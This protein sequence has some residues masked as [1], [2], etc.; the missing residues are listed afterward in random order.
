MICDANSSSLLINGYLKKANSLSREHC[1]M[2]SLYI[3]TLFLFLNIPFSFAQK[4]STK[5]V[6]LQEV[7]VKSSRI[8]SKSLSIPLTISTRLFK[9]S[10]DNRQQF[11]LKD[12][13]STIP[14]VYATNSNNFSQDLRISIRG[15]GSRSAFGIRGIKI[16]VDGIPETT[17]DG[18]GQIDNLN[19]GIIERIEVIKGPSASLYGNASGGV[20][21]IYTDNSI[22]ND[23]LKLGLTLGSD[24]VRQ[25]QSLLGLKLNKTRLFA[26]GTLTRTDGFR[27]QSSYKNNNLNL[28]INH[29]ISD[30][31][32]IN[33][34]LNYNDSPYAGDPGGL[35]LEEITDNRNQARSRNLEYKTHEKIEQL[36]SGLSMQHQWNDQTLNSYAFY[37]NRAFK[38]LLPFN[39]GGWIELDRNY[40]GLGTNYTLN[41]IRPTTKSSL[42]I[43]IDVANQRD[44][45]ERFKNETGVKGD[46]TL[47][48]IESFQSLGVFALYQISF[49]KFLIRSGIRFD[50]NRLK[51][52]DHF[53]N[54]GNQSDQI[55]LNAFSPSIGLSYEFSP[56]QFFYLN[57]STSF[58]TPVLS[59]LSAN[60][61]Q[62]GGFNKDLNSQKSTNFE[63]GYKFSSPF[64]KG[65]LS[66]FTIANKND[67]VPYELENYPDRDFY[68]NAGESNR[69]GAEANLLIRL[70]PNLLISLGYTYSDFEYVRYSSSTETYDG[71]QLPGIPKHMASLEFQYVSN[72][73]NLRLKNQLFGK[74][75]TN[76]ANTISDEGYFLS[77]LN[78]GYQLN[79]SYLKVTPFLGI[80]NIFDTDYNDNIRINAFGG[81]Y[82][83][84]APGIAF[85]GGIRL[86]RSF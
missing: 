14:G 76:D 31:T 11:S 45:R 57:V 10:Q 73:F 42:Q 63:F 17:P 15:Y 20:L 36:K 60:P 18:Q 70:Y 67:I 85:F 6:E 86:L 69:S 79:W 46:Q 50:Q 40:Y 48:Q 27:E 22:E 61:T 43:G 39:Y 71:N 74:L 12:Y 7:T 51:V 54:N 24:A 58:E 37:S 4:D 34:H 82:Y 23:Y 65:E 44:D 16:L 72:K 47:D 52:E 29:E 35:T 13:I 41:S 3:T 8:N 25:Y 62:L 28:K 9:N 83:E 32:Q 2:K 30:K 81:R 66:L 80:E 59:E 21:S 75:F 77:S 38:G 19:L 78:L 1:F 56:L 26:Q 68:R 55:D 64:V 5:V 84:P 33:W 53:M 49:Q